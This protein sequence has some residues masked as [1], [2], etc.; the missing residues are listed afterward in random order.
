M[1][2]YC[3]HRKRIRWIELVTVRLSGQVNVG[4]D[5]RLRKVTGIF[6]IADCRRSADELKIEVNNCNLVLRKIHETK[7]ATRRDRVLQ[8]P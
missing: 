4:T 6:T 1:K 5:A 7:A 3:L 8:I 2:V